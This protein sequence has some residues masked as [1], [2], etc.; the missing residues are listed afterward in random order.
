MSNIKISETPYVIHNEYDENGNEIYKK[1]TDGYW[2]KRQ[3]NSDNKLIYS[4]CADS[5]GNWHKY[6]YDFKKNKSVYYKDSIGFWVK[7]QYDAN[8]NII[9]YESSKG[10]WVKAE[11]DSLG[12]E[13]YY[14]SSS[15]YVLETKYDDN[16]NPIYYERLVSTHKKSDTFIDRIIKKIQK[17]F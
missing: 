13:T 4:Y 9:Y 11:W 12:R 5:D 10:G 3:Y 17:I 14:E 6:E 16:G 7:I 2:I 15:G 1:F 8:D